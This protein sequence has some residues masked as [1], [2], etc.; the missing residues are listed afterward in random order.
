[1]F[2]FQINGQNLL[3]IEYDRDTHSETILDPNQEEILTILYNSAGQPT[4]FVPDGDL[5]P[6]NI[7]YDERGNPVEWG[8]GELSVVNVYD[9]K[10]GYLT[11]RKLG[12]KATYRYIYKSGTKVNTPQLPQNMRQF[13]EISI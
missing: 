11:E 10:T 1:M 3:T 7:S 6:V 4:N 13:V 5:H 2:I 12:H 8:R 9:S